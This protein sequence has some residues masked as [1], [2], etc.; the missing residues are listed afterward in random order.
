MATASGLNE[1]IEI[2]AAAVIAVAIH[3]I[4]AILASVIRC[5]QLCEEDSRAKISEPLA[6][7]TPAR[8]LA[9]MLRVKA[10]QI[11]AE[12]ERMKAV[13]AA[14]IEVSNRL[15]RSDDDTDATIGIACCALDDAC[16]TTVA[17]LHKLGETPCD[18]FNA[19]DV[20]RAS[21]TDALLAA[22]KAVVEA[23]YALAT[24]DLPC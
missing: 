6:A 7:V 16:R 4:E 10:E 9:T 5:S 21:Q 2:E 23:A 13:R 14:A 11:D 19:A 3:A 12:V 1:T 15:D 24:A 17:A 20:R 8:D 18:G 22:R